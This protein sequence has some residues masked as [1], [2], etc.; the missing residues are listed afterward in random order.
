MT[1][2]TQSLTDGLPLSRFPRWGLDG[3]FLLGLALLLLVGRWHSMVYPLPLNPDESQALANVLRLPLYGG[4]WDGI[5]GTTVGPLNSWALAWPLLLGMAPSLATA[6]LTALALIWLLAVLV[7][8][9]LR[10][11]CG[12]LAAGVPVLAWVSAY[13]TTSHYDFLHYS[14]EL[15]SLALLGAANAL[16]LRGVLSARARVWPH[17]LLLGLLVG[18]VPMAKLQLAPV[19]LSL[20]VMAPWLHPAGLK[21]RL[22]QTAWSSVAALIP[23]LVFLLPLALR[24]EWQHFWNSYLVW[25]SLYVKSPLPWRGMGT[26]LLGDAALL[27]FGCFAALLVLTSA[28]WRTGAARATSRTAASVPWPVLGYTLLLLGISVWVTRKPGNLFYHYLQIP[29]PWLLQLSAFAVAP[30]WRGRRA[31]VVLGHALLLGLLSLGMARAL[32]DGPVLLGSQ[33]YDMRVPAAWPAGR[34]NLYDWLQDAPPT[35]LVWGWMPHWY[36]WAGAVPASRETH[37]YAQIVPSAL[38]AY[39]RA[40]LMTDVNAS[41][42]GL[43]LDAVRGESFGFADGGRHGPGEFPEFQ[44]WLARRYQRLTPS[45]TD[46]SCAV[47]YARKDLYAAL[48]ARWVHPVEVKA[49]PNDGD[50]PKGVLRL[51]DLSLTEDSCKDYWLLPYRTPGAV[52]LVLERPEPLTQLM[53]LN[54]GNG[55]ARDRSTREVAVVLTAPDGRTSRQ[56]V[57]LRPHP[58]W[59]LIPL[60]AGQLSTRVRIEILSYEGRGGGL[61]EV[62]LLRG[63]GRSERPGPP[64]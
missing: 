54:T 64:S 14:S 7:Y 3:L 18:A 57:N 48:A 30:A 62:L 47:S 19:A 11:L 10:P 16:A 61:N 58:F 33:R 59:T 51:L 38:Q 44:A 1:P 24:G 42:P 35:L 8:L 55:S 49:S 12:R 46:A 56:L 20:L 2:A 50:D 39:F 43:V 36:V 34:P 52:D 37:T 25:A 40:R 4:N 53:V 41:D 22:R 27:A 5:D 23:S 6:R 28:R 17:W 26:L 63:Q 60:P 45:E 13:A 32:A 21:T 15:L 31:V 29:L 9:A